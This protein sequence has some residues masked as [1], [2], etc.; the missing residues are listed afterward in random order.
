LAEKVKVT[1]L[2]SFG[3]GSRTFTPGEREVPADKVERLRARK[4][5]A[6]PEALAVEHPS[7][8]AT[9]K[10]RGS[11]SPDSMTKSQLIEEAARRGLKVSESMT[12]AEIVAALEAGK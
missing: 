8:E 1:V 4:L 2:K 11:P 10:G 3:L 5:I 12:K 6:T 9:L 7:G